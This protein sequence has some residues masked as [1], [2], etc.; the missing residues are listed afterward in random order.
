MFFLLLISLTIATETTK[1]QCVARCARHQIGKPYLLGGKGPESFDTIGLVKFCYETCDYKFPSEVTLKSLQIMGD[2]VQQKNLHEGDLI[3]PHSESV[4][5]YIGNNKVVTVSDNTEV[6][7]ELELGEVWRAKRLIPESERKLAL[8]G[9]NVVTVL[10]DGLTIRTG[11]T[12]YSDAVAVY[13]SGESFT[14]DSY[15]I[16]SECTW[17]SYVGASSGQRR[18]VCGLTSGGYCY[19]TPCPYF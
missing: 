14:Y 9:Y 18:Y 6:V 10:V 11:P 12:S 5:L 16:N 2:R 13:Y 1:Q 17:L 15:V 19:V 4:Q 7:K 8:K 3:F